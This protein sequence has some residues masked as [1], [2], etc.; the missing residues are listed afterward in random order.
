MLRVLLVDDTPD[1]ASAL[2]SV[3][4]ETGFHILDVAEPA[5]LSAP[6]RNTPDVIVVDTRVPSGAV[7]D[8]LRTITRECARP[9]VMFSR[10][11]GRGSIRAAV[12]AGVT[13]YVVDGMSAERLAPIIDT[14]IARFE[15]YQALKVE[16]QDAKLK[17][18]E[19]KLVEKAKGIL[20]KNRNLPEDQAYHA[21]RKLAMDRNQRLGD[22][23]R[24]V[25][26]FSELLG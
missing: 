1:R 19:R 22:V 12:E 9:I 13:S 16:L 25:I 5:T 20:M 24:Q 23:A 21:L 10:D 3:F 7:F 11:G 18:S 15:A 14:A 26:D 6:L 2:P 4:Q 8:S 17:L